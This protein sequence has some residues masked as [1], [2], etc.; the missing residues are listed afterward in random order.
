MITDHLP[1]PAF[2]GIGV[3]RFQQSGTG[4]GMPASSQIAH[5]GR[6]I[7]CVRSAPPDNQAASFFQGKNAKSRI[8]V[9]FIRAAGIE[10]VPMQG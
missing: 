4:R 7:D 9:N 3:H 5:D 10:Q 8:R 6:Y 2:H 1:D